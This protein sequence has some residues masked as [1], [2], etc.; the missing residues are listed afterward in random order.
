MREIVAPWL[1]EDPELGWVV[2]LANECEA[3]CEIQGREHARAMVLRVPLED[4]RIAVRQGN[5]LVRRKALQLLSVLEEAIALEALI[6]VLEH[7]PS[8]VVRHEAAYF[9]GTLKSTKVVKP[10]ADA[11]L[12]DSS[13]LVRHEAAEALGDVGS[14][15]ARGALLVATLDKS[16]IVRETAHI[17]L[18]QLNDD[19][20]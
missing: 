12:Q 14:Q 16:E 7:D 6:F 17:A 4:L 13:E 9:L 2:P 18:V 11:L 10:L 1:Q 20:S 19:E 8:P 3:I 5:S 15:Q